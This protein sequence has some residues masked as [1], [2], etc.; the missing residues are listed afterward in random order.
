[1]RVKIDSGGT[2]LPLCPCGW[3]GLPSTSRADALHEARHH[4]LRAHPGDHDVY[5]QIR[6]NRT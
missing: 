1:M 5:D 4:E 2:H 6:H 3:R